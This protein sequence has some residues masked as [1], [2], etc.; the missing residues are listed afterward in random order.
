MIK[1]GVST[2]VNTTTREVGGRERERV[3]LECLEDCWILEWCCHINPSPSE[4]R[5]RAVAS[6]FGD[7][8]LR[9]FVAHGLS[10]SWQATTWAQVPEK[11]GW[12]RFEIFTGHLA[13]DTWDGKCS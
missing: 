12:D 1:L 6:K 13:C 10:A 4:T 2:H 3:V 5:G 8:Q 7:M 9:S 11:K